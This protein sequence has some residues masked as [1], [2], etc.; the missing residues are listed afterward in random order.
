MLG[1]LR[2]KGVR[3]STNNGKLYAETA[4]RLTD[5]QR[6]YIGDNK[7][8]IIAELLTDTPTKGDIGKVNQWLDFIG[9]HEIVD[10]VLSNCLADPETMSYFVMRANDDLPKH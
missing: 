3:L 2:S 10:E 8:Q 9:E 4:I 7:R 5:V 1:G 6:Q